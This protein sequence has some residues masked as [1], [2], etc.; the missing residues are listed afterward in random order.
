MTLLEVAAMLTCQPGR[1]IST[2]KTRLRHSPVFRD[3]SSVCS[4][5]KNTGI[6]IPLGFRL[7]GGVFMSIPTEDG[8]DGEVYVYA[9]DWDA[10]ES[11][12]KETEGAT[13]ADLSLIEKPARDAVLPDGT[14]MHKATLVRYLNEYPH[15]FGES[16]KLDVNRL[17]R[18]IQGAKN[19]TKTAGP[20]QD[21]SIALAVGIRDFVEFL[22][23]TH[24][25]VGLIIEIFNARHE[26]QDEED[27]TS[28]RTRHYNPVDMAGPA[29]ATLTLEF[30]ILMCT[31]RRRAFS[32]TKSKLTVKAATC[33]QLVSM[34]Y[35]G[36]VYV[37]NSSRPL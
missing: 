4:Y 17:L 9:V 11:R 25:R 21:R 10:G 28:H 13:E 14:S 33:V 23:G 36:S 37:R 15:L 12:Y 29:P 24:R 8:N 27:A 31:K 32:I 1:I 18:V 5:P 7:D 2:M 6:L 26:S 16:Q 35:V 22:Q 19:S 3:V 30:T 34:A 20:A